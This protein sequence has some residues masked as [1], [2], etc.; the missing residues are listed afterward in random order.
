LY[1]T[2]NITFETY[3]AAAVN[4]KFY[5]PFCYRE[6]GNNHLQTVTLNGVENAYNDHGQDAEPKGIKA[7]FRMDDSGLLI[8]D[9]VCSVISN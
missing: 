9:K 2:Y 5:L 1:F 7:H 8:L 3:L 6:F 4:I